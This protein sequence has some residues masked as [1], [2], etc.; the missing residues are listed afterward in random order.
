MTNNIF[1]DKIYIMKK[2][3]YTSKQ[4]ILALS[5]LVSFISGILFTFVPQKAL[6]ES[7][8]TAL[9]PSSKAQFFDFNDFPPK[10]VASFDGGYAI[11]RDDKTLWFY[12]ED[13][14]YT[15]HEKLEQ[16][17][18]S[19]IK[20]VDND[21]LMLSDNTSLYTIDTTNLFGEPKQ[22]T[23]KN[24]PV[25]CYYF[26]TNDSYLVTLEGNTIHLYSLQ[27]TNSQR[28]EYSSL[29]D[30]LRPVC[31]DNN[32]VIYSIKG[33]NILRYDTSL[34][35]PNAPQVVY[36]FTSTPTTLTSHGDFIYFN[37]GALIKRIDANQQVAT[38]NSPT[39]ADFD[40]GNISLP[41]NF[42]FNQDNILV[43]DS[44]IKSIQEFKIE[45]DSLVFTGFAIAKGKT[46]FNRISN[47]ATDVERYKQTIAVLSNQRI[48]IIGNDENFNNFNQNCFNNIFTSE[49]PIQEPTQ[50]ALGEKSILLADQTK[51]TI[52]NLQNNT[53]LNTIEIAGDIKDVCYQGSCYYIL[54]NDLDGANM[55]FKFSFEE[56]ADSQ[57]DL[58]A[59]KLNDL[60]SEQEASCVLGVNVLGEIIA[61][62]DN[63]VT[64]ICSDL[65]GN[66]YA[67][68]NNGIYSVNKN[69]KQLTLQKQYNN[70][71]SFLLSFDKKQTFILDSENEALYLE[72]TLN[73]TAID[74]IEVPSDFIINNNTSDGILHPYTIDT[75]GSLFKITANGNNFE[76]DSLAT[77]EQE[78][79]LICNIDQINRSILVSQSGIILANTSDLT[80]KQLIATPVNQTA[81]VYTNV[82][83]Y[84]LPIITQQDSYTLKIL[85]ETIRLN[86][87]I[88]VLAKE[89]FSFLGIDYYYSSFNYNGEEFNGFI[90]VEFTTLSPISQ[91]NYV[92]FVYEKAQKVNVFAQK[93]LTNK[94]YTL[95]KGDT[96]RVFETANG[97]CKI[98]FQKDNLWIDGYIEE[99]AIQSPNKSIIKVLVVLA[100]LASMC[101]TITYFLA[102]K[103]Q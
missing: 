56:F 92:T 17:N 90:P 28:V 69:T 23:Y 33:N 95:S 50:I 55:L 72:N 32:N 71:D 21:T 66:F 93:D 8:P 98:Q 24:I 40:L 64:K 44:N 45:N 49:L 11:I 7:L 58:Q 37:E 60:S 35:E 83:A 74:T 13:S 31:I 87:G 26:D 29:S 1:Y 102:R 96:I 68:K 88:N 36:T 85:G 54:A 4:I 51:F 76:F 61:L 3:N 6:A 67:I 38:L 43:C 53:C 62:S 47:S 59:C 10:G 14:G 12:T 19:L 27:N 30:P 42:S 78:Y 52:L 100:S 57:F 101:G 79:L 97:V 99:D 94:I 86:K 91:T 103:K 39:N 89:K 41:I 80:E 73:N 65:L 18:P 81:Y 16:N 63:G 82:N 70:A 15:K 34:P 2:L 22:I 5:A 46:A 77:L 48:M 25:L 84:Y 20:A 75:K 9:L